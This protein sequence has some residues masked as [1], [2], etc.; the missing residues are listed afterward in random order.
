MTSEAGLWH[1][2]VSILVLTGLLIYMHFSQMAEQVCGD[3]RKSLVEEL[4]KRRIVSLVNRA[5]LK[6]GFHHSNK[7]R[8]TVVMVTPAFEDLELVV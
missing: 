7:P 6:H 3:E 8:V 2:S 4:S 5:S 1:A